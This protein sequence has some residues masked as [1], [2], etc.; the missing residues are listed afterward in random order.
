MAKKEDVEYA[1]L[2]DS[3][4]DDMTDIDW[5]LHRR[6][7]QRWWGKSLLKNLVYAVALLGSLIANAT[8]IWKANTYK[9]VDVSSAVSQL[10]SHA[11][12]YCKI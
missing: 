2:N 4:K 11:S 1:L 6:Q 7:H 12:P 10:R 8:L 5:E 9:M 3:E